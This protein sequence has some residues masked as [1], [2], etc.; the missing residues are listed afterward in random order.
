MANVGLAIFFVI[1]MLA[2][3]LGLASGDIGLAALCAAIALL[4]VFLR[5]D[6]VRRLPNVDPEV[7]EQVERKQSFAGSLMVLA[8]VF[9]AL[10]LSGILK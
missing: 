1:F 5:A 4:A 10:F 6:T 2:A 9:G 7:A 3:G 8:I